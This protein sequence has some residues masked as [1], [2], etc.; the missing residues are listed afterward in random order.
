[1]KA[2][3]IAEPCKVDWTKMTP[4]EGGRFCGDCKKVVKNLSSM[5]EREAR[6][7]L[8]TQNDGQLCVRYLYDKHGNMFFGADAPKP[9]VPVSM[10]SRAKRVAAVAG[11]TIASAAC[12]A[13]TDASDS[14]TSSTQAQHKDDPNDPEDHPE[15]YQN[16]GG[17]PA[18]D[19]PEIEADAGADAADAGPSDQDSDQDG[20]SAAVD[21]STPIEPN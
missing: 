7:L 14:L 4:A 17:A 1:M 16:M 19:D 21:A 5:T 20:G 6:K 11:L 8:R 3:N 9:D 12:S 10:L 18:Y 2:L 13:V 15:L